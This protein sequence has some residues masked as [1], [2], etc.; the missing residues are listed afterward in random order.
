MKETSV[1]NEKSNSTH[2]M[3]VLREFS[4]QKFSRLF[5][6]E[7]KNNELNKIFKKAYYIRLMT[8]VLY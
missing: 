6:K 1:K 7:K 5:F 4:W 2:I 8:N 3:I